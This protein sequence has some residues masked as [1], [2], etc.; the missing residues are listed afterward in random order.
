VKQES[1]DVVVIGSGFGGAVASCRL[2]QA[3]FS[4]LLLERGRRYE[5]G[6]FPALPASDRLAPDLRRL[7]WQN[8]QGLWDLQDL[9]ELVSVQAAG[10]GGGSLIYANVHLRPPANVFNDA[11]PEPFRGREKLD[12]F[13]DLAAYMLDVAPI[14]SRRGPGFTKTASLEHAMASLGRSDGFFHPPLAVN[15]TA[16]TNDF[17]E[18][19]NPCDGCGRCMGGCPKRAKNTLDLNYLA[20]AEQ[21]G[22]EVRTQCEVTG[23][24]QE[25]Y[26]QGDRP[27]RWRV[28]YTDH[29]TASSLHVSAPAVFLCAGAVHSTRLLKEAELSWQ[30]RRVKARV[31]LGYF[32]NAD[33][34][35]IAYDT[36]DQ[37]FPSSGP[38]ITTT[39]VHWD[40]QGEGFFLIQ[41]G[42]YAPELERLAG[43]LRAPLWAGRNRLSEACRNGRHAEAEPHV[44][45][46]PGVAL[47]SP[48]DA[49]LDALEEQQL[50]KV[51]SR[52]VDDAWPSFRQEIQRP[53]MMPA[54]VSA[55]IDRSS[56]ARQRVS[57]ITAWLVRRCGIDSVVPSRLRQLVRWLSSVGLGDV[58]AIGDHALLA[59][60][61]AADGGRDNWAREVLGYDATHAKRRVV[62]LAMGRDATPGVLYYDRKQR[63]LFADLDLFHLAPGYTDQERL[64]NDVAGQLGGELRVNPA[65]SFLGKPITVH[66]QGGCRMS[67]CPEDGVTQPDGQVHGCP[68]LY[69]LDGSILC[70]STGV[71]P[72]ATILAI[73]EHNVLEFIRAQ[74]NDPEWPRRDSSPGANEYKAHVGGAARWRERAQSRGWELEPPPPV[75]HVDFRSKPLGLE[76]DEVMQGYCDSVSAPR[77][78]V[79][80]PRTFCGSGEPA[81]E[82]DVTYREY[83]I[84][85]RPAHPVRLEL[86]AS[87]ADLSVFFEDYTHQL[88]LTG[89][90]VL[91]IPG[92]HYDG[93]CT[94][95]LE[96]F[97]PRYKSRGLVSKDQ[98][99]AQQ[100]ITGQPYATRVGSPDPSDDRFMRYHLSFAD[101]HW[102]LDGYKRIRQDPGL[103]AWRD[104]SAL[105]TRIGVPKPDEKGKIAPLGRGALD[106]RAAG[107]VHV[108]LTGFLYDQMPSFRV[109]GSDDPARQ[110]WAIAKF[111]AF[112]FGALQRVYAPEA[113]T[114][115]ET[116]FGAKANN[117]R[118]GA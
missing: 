23:I 81:L 25:R 24:V 30:S 78:G 38:T 5:E 84:S 20:V 42:G 58:A 105:F 52:Q 99:D 72:T 90:I 112:F 46:Y 40:E 27:P 94:G 65:F 111:N 50:E 44:T 77:L 115:L 97:T 19:Q 68:G 61:N 74:K 86:T 91:D 43:V 45:E 113:K 53:I 11:W 69:V 66:S 70:S 63:R 96:L 51:I 110:T 103:D 118:Y 75:A 36:L 82:D 49:A 28:E 12:P 22:A 41:D 15:Y 88:A 92:L 116:L 102:R 76:F 39:T 9:D 106:V 67:A 1:F 87:I 6:D 48:L 71:N 8:E 56:R 34:L 21:N 93:P 83:E 108:D 109:T 101:D 4:V 62:L 59:I 31:G 107:V 29:L 79:K 7:T 104:T 73:A 47:V 2:A 18:L 55:T 17:G 95:R 14:D 32:P 85:G 3:G 57:A 100:R 37:H 26:G 33:A 89:K 54:I 10:Y 60:L 80:P 64:M 98:R 16:K 117:V 35:S 13:F 114:A